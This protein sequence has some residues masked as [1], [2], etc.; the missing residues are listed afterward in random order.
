MRASSFLRSGWIGAGS[1]SRRS[2]A[3]TAYGP[4][5]EET[6]FIFNPQTLWD[7]EVTV[8]SARHLLAADGDPLEARRCCLEWPSD[9]R[10]GGTAVMEVDFYHHVS[11]NRHRIGKV[12]FFALPLVDRNDFSCAPEHLVTFDEAKWIAGELHECHHRSDAIQLGRSEPQP[13]RAALRRPKAVVGE[14]G[15]R[16]GEIVTRALKS[17]GTRIRT[18]TK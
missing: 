5:N 14:S 10:V 13:K 8:I 11:R 15:E 6:C 4:G 1:S 17:W 2:F 16:P 9:A 7:E 3:C 18:L 12:A